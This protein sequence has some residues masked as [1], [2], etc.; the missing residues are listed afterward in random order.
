MTN[1]K[2]LKNTDERFWKES[3]TG[4]YTLEEREE[5][6]NWVKKAQEKKNRRRIQNA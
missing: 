2:E 4:V 1:L 6:R 3:V 5:L